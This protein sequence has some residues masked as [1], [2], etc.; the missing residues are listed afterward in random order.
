MKK[1]LL[2]VFLW[3]IWQVNFLVPAS[4]AALTLQ[5]NGSGSINA[6]PSAAAY[7]LNSTVTLTATPANGWQFNG[8]SGDIAGALNPTNVLMNSDK[9][10]AANFVQIPSYTLTVNILGGGSV[11]PAGG[12]YLSNSVVQLTATPSNGWSFLQ[13]GGAASGNINPLSVTMSAHTTISAQFISPVSIITQPQDTAGSPGGTAS[14]SVTATGSG[15]LSY[16]WLFNDVNIL[17]ASSA[18]LTLTNVQPA[19]AG[20]YKVI[21]SNPYGSVTS[22]VAT[23]TVSCPGTNV[24]SVATDAALRSAIDIGGHVRLCFSGTLT[25]TNPI[26]VQKHVT[27]DGI[28]VSA[29][30]SGNQ[31]VRLFNVSTGVVFTVSNLSLIN[32]WQLGTNGANA[33]TGAAQNGEPAVGGAIYNAGGTLALYSCVLS[34]NRALGGNGGNGHTSFKTNGAGASASG[35]AIYNAGGTVLLREVVAL[36]NEARGGAGGTYTE[37]FYPKHGQGGSAFGGFVYSLSGSVM[38]EQCLLVS[39]QT[40]A[41][42]GDYTNRPVAGGGSLFQLSGS[43]SFS[44]STFWNNQA[45]GANAIN[46]GGQPAN[47]GANAQG[48]A[49]AL[50]GGTAHLL[51]LKFGANAAQGG[52]AVRFGGVGEAFGGAIYNAGTLTLSQ[53]ALEG[54]NARAGAGGAGRGPASGWG[55]GIFNDGTMVLIQST[56]ASN[57]VRGSHGYCV[58]N[59][60]GSSGTPAFGGGL[61]SVAG[62]VGWITNCTFTENQTIGGAPCSLGASSGGAY[63]G[64]IYSEGAALFL[65]NSTVAKN[66]ATNIPDS[67]LGGP[68][69]GANIA[70]TNGTVHLRGSLVATTTTNGNVWGSV[71]DDGYNMSSDGSANFLSGTSFN[72]TDPKLLPLANNGG[73][74]TTLAL[75]P[76]SPAIDWMPA[77]DLPSTDQRGFARPFGANADLGAFEAGPPLPSLNIRRNSLWIDISFIGQAGLMYRLEQSADLQTWQLAEHIAGPVISGGSISRT[78]PAGESRRFFRL[79]LDL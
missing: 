27:L 64:G 53:S 52:N 51:R 47:E 18:A 21:V 11:T 65:Q 16:A 79:T 26:D 5:T 58:G 17:G 15:P 4:A 69:A 59:P 2:M 25:L 71:S 50:A 40:W 29:I 39:N 62:S 20:A 6:T 7:P 56:I 61:S 43:L 76:D 68:I 48:G 70:N 36:A 74:T 35:G 32:G 14:F 1:T 38:A 19:M 46:L 77:V 9:N 55:G 23:L 30:I 75:A 66:L 22:V 8:W 67:Y 44:N 10:I 73:P 13:W 12:T 49:L 31:A 78:Y 28:G 60:N 37:M 54:N 3:L 33:G 63:G 42:G 24:V 41:A 45:V 34:N 57:S 72:F